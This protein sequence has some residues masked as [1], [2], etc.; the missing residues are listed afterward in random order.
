MALFCDILCFLLTLSI[1]YSYYVVKEREE[2]REMFIKA[3]RSKRKTHLV[4][5]LVQSIEM[6]QVNPNIE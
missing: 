1:V 3:Q 6:N 2:G 5:Q 4:S